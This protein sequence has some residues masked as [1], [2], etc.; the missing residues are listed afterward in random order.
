LLD[1]LLNAPRPWLP[2]LRSIALR[3]IAL[4]L[5]LLSSPVRP[6]AAAPQAGAMT[7]NEAYQHALKLSEQVQI[8]VQNRELAETTYTGALTI[9]GPQI[10]LNANANYQGRGGTEANVVG[11]PASAALQNGYSVGMTAFVNQPLFRRQIFDARRAAALGIEGAAENL[12]RAK[13]QLMFD[14]TASFIAVLQSRQQVTIAQGAI[15]RAETQLA[16]ATGRVKVG[17]ALPTEVLLA[18]I[19]LSRAQIF[20]NNAEGG[21]RQQESNFE[22]YVGQPPPATLTLP[23]TPRPTSDAL[24][25]AIVDRPDVRALHFASLQSRALVGQLQGRLFWPTLDL[26]LYAGYTIGANSGSPRPPDYSVPNYGVIGTLS[27]PLFQGGDEWI[28]VKLQRRRASI[29]AYNESFQRRIV[30]DDVRRALARVEIARRAIDIAT[31]QHKIAQQNYQLVSNHYK[32]GVATLLMVVTAQ[33]AAFE[34]E[35]N[36]ALAQY[37]HELATYQLLFAEGKIEL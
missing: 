12:R 20:L 31:E 22:R 28:Q 16:S 17:G 35:T 37:E 4:G 15:K 5:L 10:G 21:Q 24:D 8:S 25:R 7:L 23:P 29:A 33:G 2:R 3:S 19:E 6:A 26:G 27:V 1:H 18:Q 9:M 14:V 13:Q 11:Q 34:A 30:A 32:L 36:K